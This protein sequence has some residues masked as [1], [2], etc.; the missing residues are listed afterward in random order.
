MIDEKL[1]CSYLKDEIT[2]DELSLHFGLQS[3]QFLK[4]LAKYENTEFLDFQEIDETLCKILPFALLEK[5]KIVPIKS[6]KHHL[7]IARAKPCSFEIIE[8]IQSF[9]RDFFIKAVYADE[10]KITKELQKLRIKE[11]LKNLSMQLRQEWKENTKQEAMSSIS[12]IFDFIFQQALELGASDIHIEA[13]N[14]NSLIRFRIDGVLTFFTLLEKDIYEALVFHIKFLAHLNVA[15]S[16]KAQDG[17]FE[18]ELCK[19]KYDFRI[20]SVPLIYG[21][22]VVIRILKRSFDFL[23]LKN[24]SLGK[25]NYTLLHKILQAPYGM[26][27]FTGP[28]GSGKSTSLYACLN[29]IKSLEKKIITAEDPIEYKMPLVQQILLNSKAGLDFTNTLK[30]ILRQDPDIIMVGEIRDEESLDIALKS[31]LT[32]HLLLSTLHTNDALST[33]D[34]LLDMKAKSYLLASSL[35]LIV[36]QRLV[37]KLCPKCKQKIYSK[38]LKEESYEPKGCEECNHTGFIGRQLLVELLPFDE[39]LA[40]LVRKR[41]NRTELLHYAKKQGFQ[42]MFEMGLEKVKEGVTSL[43]EIIRVLQ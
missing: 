39:N 10:L 6:D 14:E 1:F 23:E 5:F 34:R 3:E 35:K 28:T 32:G 26:I 13:Q 18:F 41:K 40:E 8:E 7:Y 16:R 11:K 4:A 22:S 42:T 19:Q 30:A 15:E 2:L 24:L 17:S 33:I 37:R 27:L 38:E 12:Q 29:E 20:S 9:C 36:A 25:K 43:N 21:E 31:S